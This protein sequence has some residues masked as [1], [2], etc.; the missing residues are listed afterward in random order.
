MQLR[1]FGLKRLCVDV[2]ECARD[3]ERG[4]VRL[5]CEIVA[6]CNVEFNSPDLKCYLHFLY[7]PF[8]KY[9]FDLD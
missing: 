8:T 3:S 7:D 4:V 9:P 2:R 1:P 6:K 5:E